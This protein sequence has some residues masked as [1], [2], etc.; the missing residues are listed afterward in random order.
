MINAAREEQ[1]KCSGCSK[2]EVIIS[3]LENRD[4]VDEKIHLCRT[5]MTF[6]V[7]KDVLGKWKCEH[8][9]T[10]A[11]FLKEGMLTCQS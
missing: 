11:S 5:L 8:N 9:G 7:M 4:F 1:R 3:R 6:K 2:K 10:E